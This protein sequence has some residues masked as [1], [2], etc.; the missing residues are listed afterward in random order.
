M[1]CRARSGVK[2]NDSSDDFLQ[3]LSMTAPQSTQP[4]DSCRTPLQRTTRAILKG[5]I[6]QMRYTP[7]DLFLVSSSSWWVSLC[8]H[9]TCWL[10]CHGWV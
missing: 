2:L 9:I 10:A 5:Q 8:L 4:S 6:M 7:F 1:A 3:S